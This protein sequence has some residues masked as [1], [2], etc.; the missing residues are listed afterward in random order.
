[1]MSFLGTVG[2]QIGNILQYPLTNATAISTLAQTIASLGNVTETV[3]PAAG[4]LNDTSL[5][6]LL[7][8][9]LAHRSYNVIVPSVFPPGLAARQFNAV[10]DKNGHLVVNG[11][12]LG[13]TLARLEFARL[14]MY[15]S[16]NHRILSSQCQYTT[17]DKKG[18]KTVV[19]AAVIAQM[20][21]AVMTASGVLDSFEATLFGATSPSAPTVASAPGGPPAAGSPP[22]GPSGQAGTGGPTQQPAAPAQAPPSSGTTLQQ[23]LYADLTVQRLGETADHPS[24]DTTLHPN[25]YFVMVHALESGGNTLTKGSFW[26]TRVFFSGGSVA[27]F[28]VYKATTQR[29][30]CSGVGYAYRGFVTENQMGTGIDDNPAPGSTPTPAPGAASSPQNH[31]DA[32]PRMHYFTTGSCG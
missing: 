5:V 3:S 20:S 28:D 12:I 31:D 27:T 30:L 17:T 11:S 29:L 22:S 6:N 26:G 9:D 18:S 24:I 14:W 16:V 2:Q 4:A 19:N 15:R 10:V 8:G 25:A 32:L 7:A 13:T 21:T 23:L 1:M